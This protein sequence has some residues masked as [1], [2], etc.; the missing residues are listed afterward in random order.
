MSSSLRKKYLTVCIF[1]TAVHMIMKSDAKNGSALDS[2]MVTVY[3]YITITVSGLS[4]LSVHLKAKEMLRLYRL[5]QV[6]T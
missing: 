1:G 2:M 6:G 3:M 5:L 4:N